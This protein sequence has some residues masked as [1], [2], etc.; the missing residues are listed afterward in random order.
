MWGRDF[1]RIMKSM[2]LYLVFF[3]NRQKSL[4]R[5]KLILWQF[6]LTLLSLCDQY[7][8]KGVRMGYTSKIDLVVS[9]SELPA[10]GSELVIKH[11]ELNFY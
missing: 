8:R 5:T 11:I 6:S 10:K 7:R 3:L 9:S 2:G 4:T 1:C